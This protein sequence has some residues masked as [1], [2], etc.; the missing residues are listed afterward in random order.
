[1]CNCRSEDP[2]ECESLR[3]GQPGDVKD[4]ACMCECHTNERDEDRESE[5]DES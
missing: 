1:M 5:V 2:W 4:A 3:W